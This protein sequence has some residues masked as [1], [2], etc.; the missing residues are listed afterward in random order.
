VITGHTRVCAVIGEP[1]RHSL[2][3]ILHNAAFAAMDLDIAYVAFPVAPN[4]GA[5]AIAAV[6]TLNILGLSVTMPHKFAAAA[7]VDRL[8]PQAS[9]LQSCNIVYRDSDDAGTLWG[10]STD[11]DG[12]ISGL[13]E[14]GFSAA[15][16]RV[17]VLGAGGAGRSVIEALGRLGVADLSVV[18]RDSL[19]AA[20]AAALADLAR[21]G[22]IADIADADLIVNAT[23]VGMKPDDSLP[24]GTELLQSHQFVA[25][26]IYHPVETALLGAAR[27]LGASTMNGIPMLLHQAA[28]QVNRWT[29]L[30]APIDEMRSA[31]NAELASR[32]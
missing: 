15:G 5:E 32:A 25:D 21:V 8:T 2:S 6:R 13:T 29:G 4:A 14:A 17:V 11:G 20:S 10:D 16:K 22:T 19:K 27:R 28:L 18:N 12:F 1:V 7:A 24:A 30:D 23:S 3:P 9:R 26:L 31:L